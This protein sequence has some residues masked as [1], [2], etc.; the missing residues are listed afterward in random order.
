[1]VRQEVTTTMKISR[2]HNLEFW[3]N[4]GAMLEGWVIAASGDPESGIAQMEFG[5][6]GSNTLGIQALKGVWATLFAEGYAWLG[7]MDRGIEA[8]RLAL[9]DLANT[10]WGEH[11]YEAEPHRVRGEMLSARG[12]DAYEVE[13]AYRRA[14][15]VA[16]AQHAKSFELRTAMSLARLWQTQ[17]KASEARNLLVAIYA[18]FTEG[19]DTR[20]LKDARVLIAA[21]S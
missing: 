6:S 4:R 15:E 18:W 14:I 1:M 16:Q 12:A 8:L 5:M 19:F 21:L 7:Q 17:G 20:D 13:A 3:L 9:D 11:W 10:T 2:E